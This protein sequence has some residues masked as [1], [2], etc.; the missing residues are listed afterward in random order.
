[1]AVRGLGID[2]GSSA[3][4]AVEVAKEGGSF[5]IL[6]AASVEVDASQSFEPETFGAALRSAGIKK[7]PAVAGLTGKDLVIRYHQVPNVADWQLRQIMDFEIQDIEQQSGD[8]LASDFNLLTVSSDLTSDDIVLLALTREQQIA[9]RTARLK[10]AGV[11]VRYFT[12]NALALYHAFRVF[13]PAVSGDVVLCNIG[14]SCSDLL[15]MRDGE[16]LYARS[17]TTGGHVFTEALMEQFNVSEPKAEKL[18]RELGDLRPR[19]QRTGLTAQQEK[20][21]YALEGAAGRLHSMLTSTVQLAKSQVQL[22]RLEPSCYF[23]TGGTAN[24]PGLAEF[25]SSSLSA[26]VERFDPLAEADVATLG[27]TSSHELTEALGLAIMACEADAYSVEVLS[28]AQR[29]AR[30]FSQRH[31]FAVVATLLVVLYLLFSYFRLDADHSAAKSDR[32]KLTAAQKERKRLSSRLDALV[33]ERESLVLI[34]DALENRKASGEGLVRALQ[35]LTSAMP[36]DLWIDQVVVSQKEGERGTRQKTARPP[37]IEVS[38]AGKSRG[39]RNVRDS[40]TELVDQLRAAPELSDADQVL[41]SP[42][43]K[44]DAFDFK[45]ELNF[46]KSPRHAEEAPPTEGAR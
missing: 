21:S 45:L 26:K 20:V 41:E 19:A 17:V 24:L 39:N 7:G 46:M 29:R 36:E 15:I 42:S 34:V 5:K 16:V 28:R 11:A 27:R 43:T 35:L 23:I 44:R 8:K 14:R 6:H 38:G 30:E 37:R 25:L 13:G 2:E 31:V 32:A 4:K 9:E 22:N 3:V 18:K 10:T 1:M 40:Y 33:A 12:P